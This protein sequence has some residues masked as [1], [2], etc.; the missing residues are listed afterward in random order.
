MKVLIRFENVQLGWAARTNR[1]R[2]SSLANK[3]GSQ[4]EPQISF[5]SR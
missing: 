3:P 2:H 1:R 4:R 5:Q